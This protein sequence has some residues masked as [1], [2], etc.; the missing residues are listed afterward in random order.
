[1]KTRK[2]TQSKKVGKN[3]DVKAHLEAIK[4]SKI[5]LPSGVT[6]DM[7]NLRAVLATVV[8]AGGINEVTSV[9]TSKNLFLDQTTLASGLQEH[10][11]PSLD[12][13]GFLSTGSDGKIVFRV[14]TFVP[15][16]LQNLAEPVHIVATPHGSVPSFLTV[17]HTLMGD[18][19]A[20]DIEITV[21]AW[22]PNG[23]PAPGV[24]FDWRCR[25]NGI[26]IELL[27]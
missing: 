12:V 18:A 21:Y 7:A 11:A 25:L 23:N 20:G 8:Q 24:Q 26:V 5:N 4:G 6:L 13:S 1:M 3:P 17:E 10:L 15:Y 22:D 16:E 9:V 2:E 27:N 14:M 19:E